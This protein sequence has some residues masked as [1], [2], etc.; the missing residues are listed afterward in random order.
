MAQW[1]KNQTA[2]AQV[3]AEALALISGPAQ[4]VQGSSVAGAAA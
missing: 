2:V 4:W 1:I 3:T